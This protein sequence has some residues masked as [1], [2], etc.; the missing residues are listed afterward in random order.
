MARNQD[1]VLRLS[2]MYINWHFFHW[3][4]TNK[5]NSA[6][7]SST[8][9]TSLS[10]RNVACSQKC[11]LDIEQQAF[12]HYT[13]FNSVHVYIQKVNNCYTFTI[14]NELLITLIVHKVWYRI[15]II[16]KG[17]SWSWSQG[18]WIYNYLCNQC[19]SPLKLWVQIPLMARCTR[20]NIMW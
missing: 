17:S 6:C 18:S 3:T 7:W 1:N 4:S 13:T 2:D 20:Y 16:G 19:L 11:S 15:L 5:T 14:C 12:T 10:H 8:K 9:R